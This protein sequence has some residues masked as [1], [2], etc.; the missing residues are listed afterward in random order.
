MIAITTSEN[1][2]SGITAPLQRELDPI[3]ITSPLLFTSAM[4][5][6][7]PDLYNPFALLKMSG[8]AWPPFIYYSFATRSVQYTPFTLLAIYS[9]EIC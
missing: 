4:Q 6:S 9:L 1:N 3:F 5:A 2:K 7:K 8:E